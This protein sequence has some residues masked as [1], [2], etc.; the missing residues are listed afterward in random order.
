M[1]NSEEITKSPAAAHV[2][3]RKDFDLSDRFLEFAAK[4]IKVTYL[5]PKDSAG[6]HIGGQLIR[7]ATSMGANYEEACAAQSRADFIH[8]LQIV[9]KESRET[10]YWIRLAAKLDI[11]NMANLE[12]MLAEGRELELIV[13]KSLVTSKG[14]HS[15]GIQS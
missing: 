15:K 7:S 8:K 10:I 9:F 12:P 5:F 13:G 1:K 4:V 11:A 6:K 3:R 14:I 2:P